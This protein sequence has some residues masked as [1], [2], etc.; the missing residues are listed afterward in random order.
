MEALRRIS[1]RVKLGSLVIIALITA[2]TIYFFGAVGMNSINGQL[3]LLVD[4]S[5]EKVKLAARINQDLLAIHRAEKNV[6]LLDNV[7][8][9]R[10]QIADADKQKTEMM[11]RLAKLQTLANQD[12]KTQLNNFNSAW[13]SFEDVHKEVLR[14]AQLNSNVRARN[15]SATEGRVAADRAEK[16]MNGLLDN[17]RNL[18]QNQA[19]PKENM[20]DRTVLALQIIRDMLALHRA[21]KNMVLA[22]NDNE[23]KRLAQV[24]D[25][26]KASV[27]ERS[28]VLEK[29]LSSS[30]MSQFNEF[31]KAWNDFLQIDAKVQEATME[32]GNTLAV[33]LSINKGRERMDMAQGIMRGLVNTLDKS[34]ENDKKDSDAVYSQVSNLMLAVGLAGVI[35]CLLVGVTVTR[36]VSNSLRALF[37]GMKH[38]SSA[39][40]GE[41]SKVFN[42]VVSGLNSGADQVS[43]A[44]VQVSSASQALAS[45]AAQQAA[46]VEETSSSLEEIASMIRQNAENASQAN[47]LSHKAAAS[48]SQL[49]ESMKEMSQASQETAKIVKTIDEIA[50][51]TNLLALN[52]AVEA[53]RAGEAGAG[54]AVVAEEVRNLAQRAAEAAKNT[55]TLIEDIVWRIKDGSGRVEDASED[56]DRVTNYVAMIAS[57]SREQAQGVEQVNNAMS[58]IDKVVQQSASNS[59]ESAAASEE[60]NAQAMELRGLVGRMVV[61][62]EGNGSHAPSRRSDK[63]SVAKAPPEALPAPGMLRVKGDKARKGSPSSDRLLA[64]EED[65]QNF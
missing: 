24:I 39:E 41:T 65:F 52:A 29:S 18:Q 16:A 37:K 1:L 46:S 63:T 62:L 32:N 49:N 43:S 2:A 40:L 4:N 31:K 58:E 8:D 12:E 26:Y 36:S 25:D 5:A 35:L 15:L 30:E 61:L 7:Q 56:F 17:E 22:T 64:L 38:F 21:E 34:M 6:I 59:E 23:M 55:T 54:F 10:E 50:F 28:K 57:A 53:A 3:N 44:S 33:K 20:G 47:D 51:Q 11:G 14:L 45:G 60:M 48:M 13:N 19:D 9:M 27:T 42:E